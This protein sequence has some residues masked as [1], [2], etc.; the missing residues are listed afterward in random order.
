MIVSSKNSNFIIQNLYR[1]INT[2]Q[3]HVSFNKPKLDDQLFVDFCVFTC[4]EH[5]IVF[6]MIFRKQVKHRNQQT[7]VRYGF[8]W[9]EYG[10]VLYSFS[11]D[12]EAFNRFHLVEKLC[13][14]KSIFGYPIWIIT[15]VTTLM[16]IIQ[17]Y[18]EQWQLFGCVPYP[19]FQIYGSNFDFYNYFIYPYRYHTCKTNAVLLTSL[20]KCQ[21]HCIGKCRC[22]DLYTTPICNAYYIHFG[23]MWDA[24]EADIP[25]R[26][27]NATNMRSNI[28]LPRR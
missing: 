3:L 12:F 17:F 21:Q 9:R 16:E 18:L 20:K 11:W 8:N 5:K 10:S 27:A 26:Q 22:Y 25:N 4:I 14:L 6:V 24:L 1:L 28:S 15:I 7:Y 23:W 2:R 19:Q 13:K